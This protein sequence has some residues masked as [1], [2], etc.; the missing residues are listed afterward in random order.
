M[1]LEEPEKKEFYARPVP[2]FLLVPCHDFK[3]APSAM[4]PTQPEPF[5]LRT[6]Q[7]GRAYE[8]SLKAKL[9]EEEKK[10]KR[11][12]IPRAQLLPQSLEVPMVPHKPEPRGLTLPRPFNLR[13]EARHHEFQ[14]SHELK[15]EAEM[16]KSRVEFKALPLPRLDR[17]FQPHENNLP[18]TMP[19]DP[20]LATRSRASERAEF[21]RAM[22]EKMRLEEMQRQAEE[23]AKRMAEEEAV[24]QFRK[25]STFRA[26]PLPDFSHVLMAMPCAKPVTVPQSPKL[27]RGSKRA[28]EGRSG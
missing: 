6:D 24:R 26:K 8:Q 17:V 1:N 11:A 2:Q 13:S 14:E 9:A 21:D 25:A 23:D 28:R 7:R 16:K 5:S 12:R 15:L 27:G 18:L 3:P 19:M 4:K 20:N 10:A 22:E